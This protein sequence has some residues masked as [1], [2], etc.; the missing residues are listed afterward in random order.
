MAPVLGE[1]VYLMCKEM[2]KKKYIVPWLC[3]SVTAKMK[4]KESAGWDLDTIP[5]S[6][7]SESELRPLVSKLSVKGKIIQGQQKVSLRPLVNKKVVNMEGRQSQETTE[8]RGYSVKELFHFVDWG[9]QSPEISTT[10]N[11][12]EGCSLS[13]SRTFSVWNF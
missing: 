3:L 8:T 6:D 2:Q 13:H 5:S 11:P 4:S 9:H 1:L 10:G 12:G 7:F